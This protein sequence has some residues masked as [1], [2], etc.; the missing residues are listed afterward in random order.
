MAE[1]NE[2]SFPQSYNTDMNLAKIPLLRKIIK[3][4]LWI[5]HVDDQF[6]RTAD[7][8][9]AQFSH[10]FLW[11]STVLNMRLVEVS[12]DTITGIYQNPKSEKRINTVNREA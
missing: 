7:L 10:N 4:T 8:E 1:Q 12:L 3:K 9:T 5:S 2:M 11:L 6:G